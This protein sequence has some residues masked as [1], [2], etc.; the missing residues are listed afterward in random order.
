MQRTIV[1]II[2]LLLLGGCAAP[3]QDD[4]LKNTKKL[5]AK[6]HVS[7]YENGAFQVPHTSLKLIPAGPEPLEL[8]QE[9]VGIRARAS[10]QQAL[11]DAKESVYIIPE[12]SKYSMQLA[13]AIYG[14]MSE[15]GDSVT[16]ATRQ[17]GTW[18]IDRSSR[19]A[20]DHILASPSSGM[21]A[22]KATYAYGDKM[23]S[24]IYMEA[25]A[26]LQS[27]KEAS[28][29]TMDATFKL[30][31]N[32]S[33]STGEGAAEKFDWAADTFVIGY[34]TLPDKLAVRGENIAEAADGEKFG[35]AFDE[36][37]EIRE[38]HSVYFSEMFG[39]ALS[40]YGENVGESFGK[41]KDA[42][43]DSYEDEGVIFASLKSMRW[44]LH[45]L[46]YNGVIEPVG[47]MTV[48]AVGYVSVNGVVFPVT[49]AVK[50]G[51]AL[52]EVAVE[53]T[54]NSALGVYEVTA[55]TVGAALAGVLGSVEY[56]GGKAAAGMTLAGG[57]T[58]SGAQYAGAHMGAGMT[59]AGGFT[60][61]KSVKYIGV[62]LAAAGVTLGEASYGVVAGTAGTVAG[63]TV[64]VS[65]EVAG[66]GAKGVGAVAGG[67]VL[68]GG[69]TASVAA[70]AGIGAYQLSKAVVVPAG[71]TLTSG[72][73]LGYGTTSQLAAHSVLAVSDASY[74]VLSLEGPKWVIYAVSGN[75]PDSDKV[76]PG[77]V[78]DLEGMKEH[79][80]TIRYLP[81]SEGEIEKVVAKLPGD[82][83]EQKN[84]LSNRE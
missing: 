84:Q 41:A 19:H 55:P 36:A 54:Y 78:V 71:Y 69:T 6:G 52:T 25:D 59:A 65:G 72:V 42:F 26:F 33:E 10:F 2:G 40:D 51:I 16:G 66:A 21:A 17:A 14:G 4:P 53:V 34:T 75:L 70:G 37:W 45:G 60:A 74:L 56:V 18:I 79:G 76:A 77:S 82:L 1:W 5:V 62:P 57:A 31:G 20:V 27:G 30:S 58:L 83:P 15:T 46:I 24:E 32:I 12:G 67:T 64:L 9:L 11:K 8:A 63:G 38:E 3:S 81:V 80:E 47:K 48:G 28:A 73:V 13:E 49:L 35:R 22:G 7:L 68:V 39:S 29:D 44:A 43:V 23:E 61:G 50:E